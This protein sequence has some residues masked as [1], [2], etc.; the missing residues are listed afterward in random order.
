MSLPAFVCIQDVN[1]IDTLRIPADVPPGKYVLGLRWDCE[2]SAQV[3]SSCADIEIA[4]PQQKQEDD[5]L[6]TNTSTKKTT[7]AKKPGKCYTYCTL[8]R[9]CADECMCQSE[10]GVCVPYSDIQNKEIR[11][12]HAATRVL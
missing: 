1:I 6:Q 8:N 12:G 11:E 3:W 4:A 5:L 7:S 10:V 2:K 9:D